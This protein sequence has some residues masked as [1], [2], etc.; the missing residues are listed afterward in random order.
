LK[1]LIV[2]CCLLLILFAGCNQLPENSLSICFTGDLL[3]DRGVRL[4]IGY[5][6]I[7]SLFEEVSPI[8]RKSDFT[9]VNLECQITTIDNPQEKRYVFRANPEWLSSLREAG[10]THLNLANNHTLDH[11]IVGLEESIEYITNNTLIPTGY[12]SSSASS[13]NPCL[14]DNGKIKCALFSF[15]L[16]PLENCI[17]VDGKPYPNYST[18]E[19]VIETVEKYIADDDQIP[20]IVQFHWGLEYSL[21]ETNEQIELAHRLIDIGVDAIVGHHP[22]VVQQVEF[23]MGK[24]ILYSLGN[25]VFDNPLPETSTG[26]IA[27]LKINK[28]QD[29]IL[30]TVEINI[31]DCIPFT[32][33]EHRSG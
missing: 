30:E 31:V 24:P 22:H 16:L 32:V 15:I 18:P 10:I 7:E 9:C 25:F 12:S 33:A 19:K 2:Q 29:V 8:F 26:L 17:E 6:G 23:Y 27:I 14:L 3:L 1:S 11:S 13:N 28:N 21:I 20:V 4:K 5:A